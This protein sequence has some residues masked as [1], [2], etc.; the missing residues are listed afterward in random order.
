MWLR[1]LAISSCLVAATAHGATFTVTNLNDSGAGSLRQAVIDANA[2]AGA[3]TIAFD[4]GVTGT[5]TLTTGGMLV[6][7]ALTIQGPGPAALTID[8]NSA[9]RIFTI[10]ESPTPACPA[11]TGPSDFPVSVSGLTLRNAQRNVV[12]SSGGA[13]LSAKSLTVDNV[14]FQNNRANRAG[15]SRSSR[16][17]RGKRSRSRIRTSPATQAREIIAGSTGSHL[18]GA[19]GISGSLPSRPARCR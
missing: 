2:A 17:T 7:D 5:I 4:A 6:T 1:F 18:G 14:S 11:L 10:I 15:A 13:I 16:S 12:N 19:V 8:G 3:D 9:N